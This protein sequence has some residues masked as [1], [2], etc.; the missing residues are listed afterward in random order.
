MKYLIYMKNKLNDLMGVFELKV[1][2]KH[3]YAE[4]KNVNGKVY[5]NGNVPN[6][7]LELLSILYDDLSKVGSSLLQY[8]CLD[9]TSN[10]VYFLVKVNSLDKSITLP[11]FGKID[12]SESFYKKTINKFKKYQKQINK[13]KHDALMNAVKAQMKPKDY[14]IIVIEIL[15]F[16]LSIMVALLKN[17][18]NKDGTNC[19]EILNSM[20][21]LLLS[22]FVI[23]LQSTR[24]IV[25]SIAKGL[26]FKKDCS[27]STTIDGE[28]KQ[29][30]IKT[31]TDPK[32]F[33]NKYANYQVMNFGTNKINEAFIY[34]DSQN[35]MLD[36]RLASLPIIMKKY[37]ITLTDDSRKA[38]AYIISDKLE[39]DKTVFNGRLLGIDSDLNFE[40]LSAVWIKE[41]GYHSYVSTDEMIFKNVCVPTEPNKIVSGTKLTLN[42]LTKGLRDIENSYLTNLIGINIIVELQLNNEKYYIVNVQS[43]Y[44]DVNGSR[45]VPSASGSL[46]LKDY[47]KLKNKKQFHFKDLL[48]IGMLRELSEESYLN[49]DENMVIND[50]NLTVQ[51]F[52]M[53]G[54]ARL[55]SKA[56]KPDFFGK[57]EV[58]INST[59]DIIRI[60]ENYDNYQNKYLG[61]H[62]HELETNRMIIISKDDLFGNCL[63][64]ENLSPQLKYL[65]YL[66]KNEK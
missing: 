37:E 13:A 41:V 63:D 34:S 51:N 25:K 33:S 52:K 40:K 48:K 32:T 61:T 26:E 35:E 6:Q 27:L 10:E 5:A 44:N 66:L 21:L 15:L 62:N 57:L 20:S 49:V 54:F 43:M 8:K 29:S 53:L 42:P 64:E 45:F 7:N 36:T 50:L 22:I 65:I 18:V 31:V 56:G 59:N 46:D 47:V 55:V 58:K 11:S 9:K 2:P 12:S 1:N 30:I 23:L 16:V 28:S 39:N 14:I 4:P 60:L 17:P 24:N 3:S 38:L 19:F